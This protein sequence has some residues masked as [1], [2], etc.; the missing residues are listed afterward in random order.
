MIYSNYPVQAAATLVRRVFGWMT[1]GLSI[2][3]LTAI[4]INMIPNLQ[5][6]IAMNSG[7]ILILILAFWLRYY[8]F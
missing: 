2:T 1:L 6:A 5:K 7:I 3:G 8:L 4:L